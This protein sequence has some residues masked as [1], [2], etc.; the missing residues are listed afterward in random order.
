MY[1]FQ[2]MTRVEMKRSLLNKDLQKQVEFIV[3]YK[4]NWGL[5]YS[6]G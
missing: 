2:Y 1:F 5:F 6:Q 4:V 3:E